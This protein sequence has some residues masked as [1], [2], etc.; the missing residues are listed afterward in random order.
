[1]GI[2]VK[3]GNDISLLDKRRIWLY[4]EVNRS[5]V[6]KLGFG[7]MGIRRGR[8]RVARYLG[9]RPS[10]YEEL[11]RRVLS[12]ENESRHQLSGTMWAELR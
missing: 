2:E 10:R 8:S 5:R 7:L 11:K 1:M 4:I 6:L 3:R 9:T 12:S